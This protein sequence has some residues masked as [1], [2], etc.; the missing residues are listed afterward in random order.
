M[1]PESK[2]PHFKRKTTLADVAARAGVSRAVAGQVLN[3]GKGNTR[4]SDTSERAVR[5]AAEK[6]G[7]QPNYAARQLRGKKSLTIGILVAS[8]GDPLR[9]FLVQYLDAEAVKIGYRTLVANTIGN[10][11]VGPDQFEKQVNE[12]TRCGVDG[13]VCAVHRWFPGDREDLLRRHPNTVFYED[14]RISGGAYVTVNRA[15]AIRL[16]TEHLVERGRRRIG[17][18]LMSAKLPTG[19]ARIKGYKEALTEAGLSFDESLIFDGS[20]HGLAFSVF[21]ETRRQWKFPGEII[22]KAIDQLVEQGCADA[23]ITHDDFW[24]AELIRRLR[25]RGV[26]VPRQVA[27]VGYWNHYLADW[28][29]PPLTTVDPNQWDAAKEIIRLLQEQMDQSETKKVLGSIRR[30]IEPRLIIRAST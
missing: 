27:V 24:A 9:S 11:S 25:Q 23:V 2:K 18:A 19:V 14:P 21:D 7:Y 6:L 26:D 20:P 13:V 22:E 15:S 1:I 4:Y 8:A 28:T 29:D 5:E 12:F 3:G 16:A 30:E 17:L 10:E